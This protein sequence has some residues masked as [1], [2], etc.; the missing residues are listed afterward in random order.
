MENYDNSEK[1]T[2]QDLTDYNI[3]DE[4]QAYDLVRIKKEPLSYQVGNLSPI[5]FIGIS[6]YPPNVTLNEYLELKGKTYQELAD[7]YP[8]IL[9][10]FK[11]NDEIITWDDLFLYATRGELIYDQEN[12]EIIKRYKKYQQLGEIGKEMLD[13]IY[14]NV[15]SFS[16]SIDHHYLEDYVISY[17]DFLD[18]DDMIVSISDRL[19]YQIT[20]DPDF[21]PNEQLYNILMNLIE[22]RE[23][24]PVITWKE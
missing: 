2:S 8:E 3:L 4:Q 18:Q 6:S 7:L 22:G 19:G 1:L 11:N 16:R 15:S 9:E 13:K 5:D 12:Q 17:D 24:H 23:Y 21:P 14:G 10:V 20:D